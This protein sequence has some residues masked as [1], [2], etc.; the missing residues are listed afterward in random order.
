MREFGGDES[1][2]IGG[3]G[4]GS[5]YVLVGAESRGKAAVAARAVMLGGVVIVAVRQRLMEVLTR[6][7]ERREFV[8]WRHGQGGAL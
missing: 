8:N 1:G 2:P 3:T 6:N 5:G 7:R 4:Y